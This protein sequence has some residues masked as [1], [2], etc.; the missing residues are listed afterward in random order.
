MTEAT[1]VRVR[2]LILENRRLT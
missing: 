2:D 1:N